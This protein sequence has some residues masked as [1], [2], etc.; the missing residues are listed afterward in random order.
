MCQLDCYVQ[1]HQMMWM[2]MSSNRRICNVRI[3]TYV[4]KERGK[5]DQNPE[6]SVIS[7]VGWLTFST[8]N[9]NRQVCKQDNTGCLDDSFTKRKIDISKTDLYAYVQ[10]PPFQRKNA[11]LPQRTNTPEEEATSTRLSLVQHATTQSTEVR[12]TNAT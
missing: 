1:S 2:I 8:A 10:F 7:R 9:S 4:T 5:C 11:K 3:C 6:I 12:L